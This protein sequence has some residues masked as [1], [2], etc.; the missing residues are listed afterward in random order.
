MASPLT[1]SQFVRLLDARLK[2]VSEDTYKDLPTM[3][4]TMYNVVSGDSAWDEFMGIGAL[5]DIP[6]FKGALEY[7]PI[8]PG[9]TTRIEPAEFAGGIMFERKLTDDKKYGVLDDGSRKLTVAGQRTREKYGARLIANSFS[10]AFDFMTSEEGVSLCSSSHTT[11]SGTS[12][13]TGFDNAGSTALSK[14]S[15]NA[16]R[17]LM[18]GFKNDISERIDMD[19]SWALVVPQNL[20]DTAYEITKTVSGYEAS[21]TAANLYNTAGGGRYE[22]IVYP[23]LDDTNTNNWWLVNKTLMKQ[24][25]M[26]IDRIKPEL[27]N[28]VDFET[29]VLKSSLYMR[30]ACGFTDWRWVYGHAVA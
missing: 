10:S 23:R 30:F 25:L 3:I 20:A 14:T 22:V 19:D 2:K 15:L 26:F 6:Q 21:T 29:F 5:P 17:I 11:K 27:N 16:T 24:S 9:F 7:L 18:Q 1:S 13:T 4:P 28:T 12:T 8:S